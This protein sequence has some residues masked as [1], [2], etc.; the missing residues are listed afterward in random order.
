MTTFT[1]VNPE[2][3]ASFGP[4]FL[5]HTMDDV[6]QIIEKA[7]ANQQHIA[8][9]SPKRRGEFLTAIGHQLESRRPEIVAIAVRESGLPEKRINSEL[10]R[11]I[12]QLMH[13][14]EAMQLGQ[15][16][17][18][19]IDLAD[20]NYSM[21]PRPDLRKQL[22]PLGTVAIFGAS[23][24]PL[25]FSTGGN[26][27][28]SALAGGNAV[29]V[30]GHPSHPQTSQLVFDC[31]QSTII[32]FQLP[33][34]T[35][36]L[37][38]GDDPQLT[39]WVAQHPKISAIG[40]TGSGKVGRLLVKLG[41]ERKIPI[42]VFAEMGAINPVFVSSKAIKERGS[43]LAKSAVDSIML[44]SGQ[45]CTKPGLFIISKA[46][47][48]V[49]ISDVSAHLK[50]IDAGPL[51]NRGIKERYYENLSMMSKFNFKEI[52]S[53]Y[54]EEVGF[55]V[56]PIIYIS[57]WDVVAANPELLEERFGPTAI[58]A[59]ADESMFESVALTLEGQLTAT[60]HAGTNENFNSLISI[61]SERAGRII[62]N[63]FPTGVSVTNAMQHGGPWPSSS[64]PT[65]SVGSDAA[66]RF[67][68]PVAYQGMPDDQLPPALQN[69]NPWGIYRLI[70]GNRT[71]REI[72]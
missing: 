44:G 70:N 59:V 50:S 27:T 3:A 52:R 36:S 43:E 12:F 9:L 23:N 49:F 62:W 21:G 17:Q 47:A 30:K 55:M 65:T 32:D 42:P 19:T 48:D 60:I 57:E 63:S 31:F 10:T 8:A 66:Y 26:D 15:Y 29:V 14:A 54:P 28:V 33:A 46:M 41:A 6:N 69:R 22:Q 5:C 2:N 72:D 4:N 71:A 35:M 56:P 1:S 39:Y 20:P 53:D 68:R 45:F 34:E 64:T 18:A 37:I 25:A 13:F 51:L 67:L 16:L 7:H 38:Q 58:L 61:V 24:F 11:A 40:F